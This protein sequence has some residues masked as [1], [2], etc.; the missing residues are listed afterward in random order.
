MGIRNCINLI[1]GHNRRL[2]RIGNGI[3]NK[4]LSLAAKLCNRSGIYH[5]QKL[6]GSKHKDIC[7]CIHVLQQLILALVISHNLRGPCNV[8]FRMRCGK[9]LLLL[10]HNSGIHLV[11]CTPYLQRYI[12]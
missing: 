11:L 5:F 2:Y 12:R 1:P 7:S 6:V 8:P 9:C 10:L 3:L 4:L